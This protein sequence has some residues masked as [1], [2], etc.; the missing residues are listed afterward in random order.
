MRTVKIWE[1]SRAYA[2]VLEIDSYSDY[3]LIRMNEKNV[4]GSEDSFFNER[5]EEILYQYIPLR[6][7]TDFKRLFDVITKSSATV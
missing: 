7:F 5:L 6:I 2:T 1:E 4:S 3:F